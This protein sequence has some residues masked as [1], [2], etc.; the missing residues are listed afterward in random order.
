MQRS[1]SHKGYPYDNT[2]AEAKFKAVKTEFVSNTIFDSLEQLRLPFN[3]YI[4]WFN[5]NRFHSSLN[6]PSPI[7]YKIN[8]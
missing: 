7:E 8:L 3:H 2:V 5:D 4:D 1:L 6:Y